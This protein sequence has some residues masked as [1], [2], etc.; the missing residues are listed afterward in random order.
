MNGS[1]P[2][3]SGDRLPLYGAEKAELPADEM[4]ESEKV[5]TTDPERWKVG[6]ST[7]LSLIRSHSCAELSHGSSGVSRRGAGVFGGVTARCS[8]CM[9]ASS[10]CVEGVGCNTGLECI[11]N[12]SIASDISIVG[13]AGALLSVANGAEMRGLLL[14]LYVCLGGGGGS[15]TACASERG[16]GV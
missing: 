1:V 2:S 5:D 16:S 4:E 9:G 6:L 14:I 13:M 15:V 7:R 12:M 10:P 8:D 11:G 3:L